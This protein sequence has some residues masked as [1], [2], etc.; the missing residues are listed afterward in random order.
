MHVEDAHLVETLVSAETVF[1]GN[2][3]HVRRDVVRTPSGREASREVIEHPGA[4][5][6][7]VQD[8]QGR[9]CLVRQYRHATGS[10]LVE[11]PAGKLDRRPDGTTEEPLR[12]AQRELAEE[13]QLRAG[14]W[15]HL[16]D[17]YLAAGY[18]S[19]KMSLFR[20]LDL[21]PVD[22]R[23]D[24]DEFLECVWWSADEAIAAVRGGQ[25]VDSKTIIGLSF[26]LSGGWG[27]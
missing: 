9:V 2:L 13:C 26:L 8:E 10:V 19:E 21:A 24:D 17:F 18:S 1:A 20:A 5:A 6:I 7:L 11:L 3:L 15:H 14:T 16:L 25:I 22:G 12:A 23:P 4:V 27:G